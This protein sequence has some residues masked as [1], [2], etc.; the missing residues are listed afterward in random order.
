MH[1]RDGIERSASPIGYGHIYTWIT[2]R[3]GDATAAMT[4]I[5]TLRLTIRHGN[6]GWLAGGG[7]ARV[8]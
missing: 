3:I 7:Q 1:N 5:R 4:L 6:D 2:I 8:S